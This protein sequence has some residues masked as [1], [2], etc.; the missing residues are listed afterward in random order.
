MSCSLRVREV[1]LVSFTCSFERIGH[2]IESSD[3][4]YLFLVTYNEIVLFIPQT[5]NKTCTTT[6]TT[7]T[8]KIRIQLTIQVHQQPQLNSLEPSKILKGKIMF[9]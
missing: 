6:M 8:R 3:H 2:I 4:N 5:S 1:I 7:S 9:L